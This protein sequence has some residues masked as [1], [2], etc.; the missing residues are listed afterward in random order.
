MGDR[1][2]FSCCVTWGP[3]SLF[4]LAASFSAVVSQPVERQ[5]QQRERDPPHPKAP[6]DVVGAV[7]LLQRAWPNTCSLGPNSTSSP[8]C[9]KATLVGYA[10]MPCLQVVRDD[11]DRK[12]CHE[13][14]RSS[15]SMI[16]VE[17]G[18]SAEHGSSSSSTSGSA[19]SAR[20]MHSSLAAGRPRVAAPGDRGSPAT[21]VVEPGSAAGAS[22]TGVLQPAPPRFAPSACAGELCSTSALGDVVEDAHS[23][24][25]LVAAGRPSR[26][27][28]P[29]LVDLELMDLLGVEA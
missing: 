27:R 28:R 5:R 29:Q 7:R 18:S 16:A 17:I 21:L 10:K 14:R 22:V 8:R 13:V 24:N 15:C 6:L 23:G 9:M 11:H 2:P 25:G 4:Q 26:T 19:A 1:E 12:R 3:P 20:A